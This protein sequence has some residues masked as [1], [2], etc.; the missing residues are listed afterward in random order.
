MPRVYISGRVCIHRVDIV[1]RVMILT[2]RFPC[3]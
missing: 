1:G 3:R 2:S